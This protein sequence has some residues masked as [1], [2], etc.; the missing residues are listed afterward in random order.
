MISY[1]SLH[2]EQIAS[3]KKIC[4]LFKL[5]ACDDVLKNAINACSFSTMQKK[6]KSAI[7]P[8]LST[9]INN[10]PNSRKVRS[11]KIGEHRSFFSDDEL[12][13]INQ[14]ISSELDPSFGY[15]S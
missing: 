4:T 5:N 8:R 12:N 3:L 6:E 7:S 14:I 15:H 13:D 11:G 1:E 2:K 10:E 9:A